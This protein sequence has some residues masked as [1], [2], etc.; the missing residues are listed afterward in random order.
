MKDIKK[1]ILIRVYLVY[2]GILIFGFAVIGKALYIQYFEGKEL[3]K[4]AQ[5]QEMRLFDVEAIRGNICSDDGTLLATS[6]P[7]F[8]VRMDV[9]SENINDEFFSQNVDSLSIYL[10]RLF[11]DKKVSEYK[12]ILWDARR[13][14][15]RYLLIRRDITYTELKQMRKFPIFPAREIQRRYDRIAKLQKGTTL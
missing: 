11:K 7:I 3:L 4:K 8:D 6:I 12:E 10:S 5:K 14:K 13:N 1:D 15:E 2:L 9:S